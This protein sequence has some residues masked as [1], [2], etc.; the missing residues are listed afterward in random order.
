MFDIIPNVNSRHIIT[1]LSLVDL[2]QTIK[3]PSLLNKEAIL[4]A[5]KFGKYTPEYDSVKKSL[6]CFIPNFNH[7]DYVKAS[8]I[9]KYT[10][11]VYID[12]D[13]DIDID[14]SS[15]DFVASSWRSISGI[16]RGILVAVDVDWGD[17]IVKEHISKIVNTISDM[18]DIKPDQAA[19]SRDRLCVL[20]Y[21]PYVYFNNEYIP[22]K[23]TIDKEDKKGSPTNNTLSHIK[24][25]KNDTFYNTIRYSNLEDFTKDYVF[26]DDEIMKDLD[27]A[28][29]PYC[30]I[31]IPPKIEKGKRNIRLF[32]IA[33]AMKGLNPNIEE[34]N[35]YAFM[36]K[37]NSSRCEEPLE[38]NEMKQLVKRVFK[39]EIVLFSNKT[40]RFL[41]NPIYTLDGNDRKSLARTAM[42][43][44]TLEKSDIKV[45]TAIENWD[46]A[47][48]MTLK[49][50]AVASGLSYP[51][52]KRKKWIKEE[53]NLYYSK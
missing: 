25:E 6:N 40:K 43:K 21:D 51:T 41:F 27:G 8:T 7:K 46:S 42:N 39:S 35:F 20:S 53:I 30:E 36:Y 31:Y 3:E 5:R 49:N 34:G 24:L 1:Q 4:F 52:I 32:N 15:F 33:T 22:I 10:G 50:I 18:L 19:V 45:K 14:F 29:I 12:V 16:G 47:L 23:L 2:V 37:V 11:F 28:K 9:Y 26:E 38:P 17:K 48:K 13:E 44:K